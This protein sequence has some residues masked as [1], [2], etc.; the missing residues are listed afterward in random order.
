MVT[1]ASKGA[2]D[3]SSCANFKAVTVNHIHLNW[4][5]DFAEKALVGK[6]VLD[7]EALEDAK[8]IVSL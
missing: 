6:A 1:T 3:R 7:V 8:Q 5:V 4:L 2:E